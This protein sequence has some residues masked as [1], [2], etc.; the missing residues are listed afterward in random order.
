MV[1][2]PRENKGKDAQDRTAT[3]WALQVQCLQ[4]RGARDCR[5]RT[6]AMRH[7]KEDIDGQTMKKDLRCFV[8][9]CSVSS[10]SLLGYL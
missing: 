1:H 7:C 2:F 4:G 6:A 9:E 3:T 5:E 10:T 8:W